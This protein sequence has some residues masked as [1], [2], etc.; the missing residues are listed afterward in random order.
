MQPPPAK[1]KPEAGPPKGGERRV[2]NALLKSLTGKRQ[3]TAE[4][5][6]TVM[7]ITMEKVLEAVQAQAITVYIMG[8]D[9]LIHFRYN[10]LS[11]SLWGGDAEKE[12][13]FREGQK[14]LLGMTLKPGQGIVGIVID[15]GKSYVSIDAQNDPN[16][17]RGADKETG[18][19]SQSMITVPIQGREKVLGAIQ[20]IN[21]DGARGMVF[22]TKDDVALLEEVAQYSSKVIQKVQNPEFVLTD[23]E[24]AQYISKL[25]NF[26]Y[27][28][29]DK[30]FELNPKMVELVGADI[31]AELQVIPVEKTGEHAVRVVM[32]N[33]LDWQK[34]ET[35]QMKTGLEVSE[36]FVS[37]RDQIE[38]LV[39]AL[40]PQSTSDIS[41]VAGRVKEEY[42]AGPEEIKVEEG[43]DEDSAP[44]VQ[45][46]NR[47]IED[48]YVQGT[49][50]IHIEP[51]EK[52][53]IV[54]Y[55]IDGLCHEKLRLPRSSHAALISRLKIMASVDISEKRL[56]QD[57]RIV[58]KNF[59]KTGVDVDLRV[60]TAPN[61]F[62]EKVCMR[63]LDK[64]KSALPLDKLGFSEYNLKLYREIL[65]APY[66]MILHCGPTGSGKSMTLYSALGEINSPDMNIQTAEDPIEYTLQGVNQMQM[67]KEIGLTFARALRCFLRQDPDI[68]LVGEMRDT[69]TAEIG[70][71]AALTGHLLFSTLHTNDAP[72]TVT[73][74]LEMGIEPF[75]VS[76]TLLC[77]CSQRLMRR[78]C[79]CKVA[80][81]PD[82]RER[83]LLDVKPDA[84]IQIFKKGGCPKCGG[85]GYKGRTGVH[86]L[87]TMNDET[88]AIVNRG[89]NA[90]EVRVAA[91][92]NGMV[93]LHK[94][95]MLKVRQGIASMEE[96][97]SCVTPDSP[98]ILKLHADVWAERTRREAEE[99][100][101]KAAKAEAEN[102]EAAKA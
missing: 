52:E 74:F 64:T 16:F 3:L 19:Q 101:R 95:T 35:F 69:E 2:L 71:E 27:M 37:P 88:K 21:K 79:K 11:P 61:N 4:D 12:A 53:T 94:D 72:T 24:M 80:Y 55:R 26:P 77:V 78:L 31:L 1:R 57:G 76:S 38:N 92:K 56:P 28:R 102:A 7:K 17:Y 10:Y 73:R 96:A 47:I 45:L 90:E 5:E 98:E 59:T 70:I 43:A 58:F 32:S 84:K 68:I 87:M 50:D 48:A 60:S 85:S 65:Q 62:G 9:N 63:I 15:K 14:R 97:M 39:K 54:R 49:S 83:I 20:V 66:G 81:E 23:E 6:E 40:K 93:T 25:T 18:F 51:W 86:E 8:E 33:P 41:D 100:A 91:I 42:T 44:I 67:K 29:L 34:K 36:I 82:E 22:F 89:G 75:M 30:D 13:K 46:A 99:A